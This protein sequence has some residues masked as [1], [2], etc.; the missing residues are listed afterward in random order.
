MLCI[1][2]F[3][4]NNGGLSLRKKSAIL[5]ALDND[6]YN[7]KYRENEDVYFSFYILLKKLNYLAQKQFFRKNHLA[8]I[9][10]I[11]IYQ[12]TN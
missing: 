2:I 9:I 8:R 6:T 4:T 7:I 12:K 10:V 1:Y 3:Y 5:H 11:R